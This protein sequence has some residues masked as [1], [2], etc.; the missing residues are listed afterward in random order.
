MRISLLIVPYDSGMRGKRMGAGPG[1]LVSRGLADRLTRDGHTVTIEWIE[2]PPGF[3]A[4]EI[5][6]AFELA[7]L[8]SAAVGRSIAD[9]AF[10]LIVSGN[11]GT[12]L[13]TIAGMG[14]RDL[15]IVW[16]DAH[17]DFNTPD[18]T[19]SG[20]FDGMA[21]ATATGRCWRRAVESLPGFHPVSESRVVH[22]GARD[23]D[24]AERTM[25]DESGVTVLRSDQVRSGFR[26]A[27]EAK[28]SEVSEVYLH[29]DLDVLDSTEGSANSYAVG[30]GLSADEIATA[31]G[32]VTEVFKVRAAA[33]TSYDPEFDPDGKVA[34]IAINLAASIAAGLD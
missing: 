18:T 22:V 14:R 12:C 31:L 7:N 6:V 26:R 33:F 28:R 1:H 30:G 20:F 19:V 23:F 34:A 29:V 3:F 11:C 17:G 9:G 10:P 27:L 8:L 15:G 32:D 13:G 24:S 21:L 5:A 4:A 16:L 2:L 25:L